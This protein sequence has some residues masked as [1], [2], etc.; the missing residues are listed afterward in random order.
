VID[1]WPLTEA[2]EG[3]NRIIFMFYRQTA[4][5]ALSVAGTIC[6]DPGGGRR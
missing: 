2:T 6:R 5:E 3:V 1:L 4:I